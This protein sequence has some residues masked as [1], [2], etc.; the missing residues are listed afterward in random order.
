MDTK[1]D[2]GWEVVT[3]INPFPKSFSDRIFA[4]VLKMAEGAHSTFSDWGIT[5]FAADAVALGRHAMSMI[6]TTLPSR[7]G[8]Y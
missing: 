6:Q 1:K 7:F 4:D 5:F 2:F 8:H 3:K